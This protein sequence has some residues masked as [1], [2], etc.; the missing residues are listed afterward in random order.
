[1]ILASGEFDIAA[2]GDVHRVI[3]SAA[4]AQG[5]R[6]RVSI[7]LSRVDF[8]DAAMLNALVAERRSLQAAGG[9]LVIVGVT[10]WSMRVIDICGL[11][12]T[13]GL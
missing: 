10:N 5:P 7:D 13:L 6:P 4:S 2:V 8:L 9:D 1:M 3:A 12:E 11:R